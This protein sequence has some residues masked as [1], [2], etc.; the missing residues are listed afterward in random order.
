MPS[1]GWSGVNLA[2]IGLKQWKCILWQFDGKIWV[3]RMPGERQ[4]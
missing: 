4:L 3:W 1:I 2:A